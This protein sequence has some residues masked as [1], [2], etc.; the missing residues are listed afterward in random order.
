MT[1][2]GS[3][4]LDPA[5]ECGS[6]TGKLGSRAHRQA[7]FRQFACNTKL[8]VTLPDHL[9]NIS[10]SCT[11]CLHRCG[12]RAADCCPFPRRYPSIQSNPS[13]QKLPFPSLKSE[14]LIV[15]CR[16]RGIKLQLPLLLLS[17]TLPPSY[18]TR[19]MAIL[20]PCTHTHSK[21]SQIPLSHPPGLPVLNI[22]SLTF[23][24]FPYNQTL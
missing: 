5:K 2:L 10:C 19:P 22:L 7:N 3:C 18:G 8:L 11:Y 9:K 14:G 21:A 16:A 15:T 1:P 20:L 13:A 6:I 23:F 24:F 17:P 12:P 4:R